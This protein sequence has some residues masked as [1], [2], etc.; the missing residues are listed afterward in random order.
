M[1][2]QYYLPT[3][4][5]LNASVPS[6]LDASQVASDW[7]IKFTA[8]IESADIDS[9]LSLLVEDA[10]WRDVL[11]I[12]W[13]FR[14]IYGTPKITQFL[15][16]RVSKANLKGFNLHS[17]G[18]EQPFPDLAWIQGLFSFEIGELGI[19]EGVFRIVPTSTGEW[20]GHCVYTNLETLKD[21]PEKIGHHRE[22]HP[23][24][25]KWVENRRREQEFQDTEPYVIVIGGGQCGLETAAR[26]KYLDIPTLV[27]EKEPRIG[28]KWRNRY[29]AL[30]LNDPVCKFEA[31][32]NVEKRS[33]RL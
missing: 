33:S 11:S 30:C 22:P 25:G 19:G 23:T 27:I 2:S 24:R 6:D 8:S 18:F 5:R 28:N 12:T 7:F 17:V 9:I 32:F 29:D 26:L 21:F 4:D 10:Y 14:T 31:L 3:L 13:D 15:Q 16:D 20:K 1:S